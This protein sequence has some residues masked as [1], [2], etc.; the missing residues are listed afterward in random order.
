MDEAQMNVAKASLSRW[1]MSSREVG[2][3]PAKIECI[4]TF[5]MD[6]LT[7]YMFKFK[8]STLGKWLLGVCGGFPYG[9]LEHC[10]HV[11]S[12]MEEYNKINAERKAMQMVDIVKEYAKDQAKRKR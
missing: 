5:D 1:L 6:N 12:Q 9:E 10:G 11:C 2:K 8:K 7:Y 3:A 4:G